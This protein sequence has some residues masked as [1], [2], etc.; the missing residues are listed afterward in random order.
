MRINILKNN[1]YIDIVNSEDNKL[2]SYL[3]SFPKSKFLLLSDDNV[4]RIYEDRIGKILDGLDFE[5]FIIDNGEHSKSLENYTLINQFLL[6]KNFT[7]SDKI[8]AFGGGVVGDLG[9]FVASTYLRGIDLI[10]IPT[11]LLAMVDS[12]VGGKNGVN[13]LGLKN[14]IGTFY[15][16]KIVY[17]DTSFLDTL[18][19]RN[20]RNGFSEIFKA[21]LLSDKEFYY[22]LKNTNDLDFEKVIKRAIEI[23]LSFVENDEFDNGK[24][25]MLNLGHTLGHALEAL[26]KGGLNHGESVAI[27]I[28]YMAKLANCLGL[29]KKYLEDELIETFSKYKIPTNY[30][31][32]TSQVIDIIRH[33][34]KI[35]DNM[36]NIIIPIEVGRAVQKKVSIEELE[37]LLNMVS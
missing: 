8:I 20:M 1:Y 14:Q 32:S 13:F 27:G 24:R 25:Q 15:F 35:K 23:K 4:Y 19:E 21:S 6:E 31:F 29:G 34:K 22:Y 36:I 10:S 12:S 30:K 9:G 33:D 3:D 26:S 17:I 7:R 2:R 16:P 28:V 18:D 37:K 5:V 11:S